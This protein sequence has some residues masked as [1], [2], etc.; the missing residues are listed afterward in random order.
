MADAILEVKE[1]RT[2]RESL[3]RNGLNYARA[4]DWDHRKGAYLDLVDSLTTET[5]ADIAPQVLSR[6]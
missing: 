6:S 2:L 5:F 4:N 1:N 3:V